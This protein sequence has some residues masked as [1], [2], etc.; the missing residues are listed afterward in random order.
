M[1]FY[2]T[3]IYIHIISMLAIENNTE[4]HPIL[5]YKIYN[6]LSELHNQGKKIA[7]C[8][9]SVHIGIKG[10]E[11]VDKTAKQAIDMPEMNMTRLPHTDYYLTIR[12]ARNSEWERK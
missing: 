10:N 9:T 6:I 3:N 5:S 2:F 1:Y 12:R 8:K 11:E 7:I 4:N